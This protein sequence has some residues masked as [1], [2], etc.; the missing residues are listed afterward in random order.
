MSCRCYHS[1]TLPR[2]TLGW[3]VLCDC[4]MS[5]SYSFIFCFLSSFAIILLGKKESWLLYFPCLLEVMWLLSFLSSSSRCCGLVCTVSLWHFLVI[6]T[7]L[8]FV[9]VLL[10]LSYSVMGGSVI[11]ECVISWSYAPTYCSSVFYCLFLT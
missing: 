10:S 2:G 1:L 8:S 11:C 5:S 7:Y 3:S 4:S 9:C 6:L